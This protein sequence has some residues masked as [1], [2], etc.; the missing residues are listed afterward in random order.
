NRLTQGQL[1]GAGHSGG[2]QFG[3]INVVRSSK[4][5]Q[6]LGAL[7]RPV[8]QKP[9]WSPVV[10]PQPDLKLTPEG[11]VLLARDHTTSLGGVSQSIS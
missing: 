7:V 8:G 4:Q 11:L 5:L 6:D 10:P 9:V 3:V 2:S 1:V